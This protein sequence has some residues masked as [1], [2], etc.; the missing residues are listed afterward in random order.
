MSPFWQD[1]VAISLA[2]SAAGYLSWQGWRYVL[3]RRRAACGGGG[4]HRCGASAA[5]KEK[6]LVV[7][8]PGPSPN[9][10]QK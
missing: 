4:C 6:P 2:A 10:K 7:F 5:P 8:E 9:Q 1:V 3:G